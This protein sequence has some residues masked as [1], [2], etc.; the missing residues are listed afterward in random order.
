MRILLTNDDGIHAPGIVALEKIARSL[1]DDVW[2]VAPETD[3][4]GLAHSLTLSEPL[5]LRE[6]GEKRFA[7]RGTPTDCVIMAIRKVLDRKP[8]LVLSGVNAGANLADDV[9]YSGT[10]AG[11]IE[12]TVHGVRSFALSQAYSYEAGA[13]I[14][15]HVAEA[16]APDL[17]R[18]L[19][20]LDLPPGTF[21]NLNFP[22][23]EPDEAEGVEVTAQGK[24]EFGLSVEERHDGRGLPYYWLRFGDRKGNYR[25]G[26]DIHALRAKKVSVTPLKLDM[27]DYAVQDLVAEALGQGDLG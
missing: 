6:L 9:T 7:L 26:T 1:S 4:S 5:R 13:P 17:L 21:L 22:H 15:W 25:A 3:Q 14:P 10:V 11:A 27:T 19:M 16:L 8:D 20:T 12:G 24:L 18:K 23:C 2:I